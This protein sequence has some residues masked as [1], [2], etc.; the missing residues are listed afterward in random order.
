MAIVK[1]MDDVLVLNKIR[2]Y[3]EIRDHKKLD[4]PEKKAVK[5]GEL[6]LAMSLIE[7]LTKKFDLSKYKD[8]YKEKIMEV[9]EAKAHGKDKKIKKLEPVTT[10]TK[11]LM[12][13]LKA[14]LENAK[15]AS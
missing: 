1:P 9:I 15:K 12:A 10:K 3:E 5:G 11:D 7:Q 2:F 8:T 13:Q 14:S 6:D 4:L